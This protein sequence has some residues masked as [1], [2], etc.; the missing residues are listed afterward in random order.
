MHSFGLFDADSHPIE[1]LENF[2]RF[3]IAEG[4]SNALSCFEQFLAKK[5]SKLFIS[6]KHTLAR[7]ARRAHFSLRVM[8][9]KGVAKNSLW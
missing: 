9:P 7:G 5:C 3:S 8:L 2:Q 4:R 1:I 6:G